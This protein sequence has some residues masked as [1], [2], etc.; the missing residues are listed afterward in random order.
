MAIIGTAE[1]LVITSILFLV[2]FFKTSSKAK[3]PDT[4]AFSRLRF[5]LTIL[6]AVPAFFFVLI[7]T[8]GFIRVISE[9]PEEIWNFLPALGAV[10]LSSLTF[11]V[12]PYL[13]GFLL[14]RTLFSRSAPQLERNEPR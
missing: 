9:G 12:A 14:K 2:G 10:V 6:L 5:H 13:F 11:I 4:E 7:T 3:S 8:M 1:L